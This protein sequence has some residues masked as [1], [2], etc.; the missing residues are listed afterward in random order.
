MGR[1]WAPTA[2]VLYLAALAAGTLGPSPAVLFDVVAVQARG[3]GLEWVSWRAVEVA[4]NVL[5]FLPLAF[6]LRA[7]L[8]RL[9]GWLVWAFCSGASASVEVVQSVLPDRQ[10]SLLDLATNSA[11]AAAG[12]LLA[13]ALTRGPRSGSGGRP[14]PPQG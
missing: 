14:R 4:S 1:W 7:A 13:V 8:P 9:S 5:L 10:P 12:V 11:G 6:L 2:L 3:V